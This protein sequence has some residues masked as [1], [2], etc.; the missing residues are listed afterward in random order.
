MIDS[1]SDSSIISE[2]IAKHLELKIDRKKVHRLNGVAS[3]SHSLGTVDSVPV[4]IEDGKNRDTI[5][6]EFSVVSTEYDDNGK[7][8]SLF[9]LGT[10]W[11]YQAG[12]ESL[13][14]GEFKA[15]RNGKTIT[16]PLSVHKYQRNV[17]TVGKEKKLSLP[18][19]KASD[20]ICQHCG[21]EFRYPSN[22][23]QHFL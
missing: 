13:V 9:I 14:K 6:D 15:S 11:Q 20:R 22:L 4:T 23:R 5:L 21:K 16:I 17:F 12:W 7:E 8:L 18:R 19:S 2:N 3:K 10:Q 1:G